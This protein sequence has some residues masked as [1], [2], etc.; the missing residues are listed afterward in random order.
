M[1]NFNDNIKG[2]ELKE[3]KG[4]F[5]VCNPNKPFEEYVIVFPKQ[6]KEGFTYDHYLECGIPPCT[7]KSHH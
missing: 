7:S 2:Q 1:K 3:D 4:F 6:Y 5:V